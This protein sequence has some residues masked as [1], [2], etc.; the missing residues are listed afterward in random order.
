MSWCEVSK[1]GH[2]KSKSTPIVVKILT[3]SCQKHF[4][5]FNI[6]FWK[7]T[8]VF[9]V[10]V[11]IQKPCWFYLCLE[12]F[13]T[14]CLPNKRMEKVKNTIETLNTDISPLVLP[15]REEGWEP[16]LKVANNWQ[17]RPEILQQQFILT[18]NLQAFEIHTTSM[19][20]LY[21]NK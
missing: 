11:F 12:V 15:V 5:F 7:M 20:C 19:Y 2:V 3:I 16:D 8:W 4:I 9:L 1:G 6:Q 21:R 13:L 10:Y 17:W 14:N 18:W